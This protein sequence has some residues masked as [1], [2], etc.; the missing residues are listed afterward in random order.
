VALGI[1]VFVG[2]RSE[3]SA[4]SALRDLPPPAR[5][6]LLAKAAVVATLA[7]LPLAMALPPTGDVSSA[8]GLQLPRLSGAWEGPRAAAS[9]WQPTFV[10]ASASARGAYYSGSRVVEVYVA[11]YATQEQGRELVNA[12]NTFWSADWAARDTGTWSSRLSSRQRTRIVDA[13]DG[14]RW[15]V[16]YFY[17]VSG[18]RTGS[19]VLAQLFYGVSS[20]MSATPSRVGVAAYRCG[21]V[22]DDGANIVSALLDAADYFD[23]VESH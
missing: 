16:T 9:N 13:P 23:G 15:I 3:P 18:L 5:S 22:C 10:G 20:W 7:L 8:S 17:S 19:P 14:G 21:E 4:P 12:G 1:V 6:P 2:A 11:E